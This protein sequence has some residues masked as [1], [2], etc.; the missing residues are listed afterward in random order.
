MDIA[1]VGSM[2]SLII[3]RFHVFMVVELWEGAVI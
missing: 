1:K 3:I 2:L